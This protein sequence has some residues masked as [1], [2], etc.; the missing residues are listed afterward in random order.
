MKKKV[1]SDR[2]P[3]ES[4]ISEQESNSDVNYLF[5]QSLSSSKKAWTKEDSI[6][7][8]LNDNSIFQVNLAVALNEYN[9]I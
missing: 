5:A 3:E 2:N 6:H 1:L 8:F 7:D 4:E 9:L